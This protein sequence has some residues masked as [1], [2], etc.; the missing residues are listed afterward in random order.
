MEYNCPKCSTMVTM[1]GL[2]V[3]TGCGYAPPHGAD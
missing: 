3:C 2:E 1:D